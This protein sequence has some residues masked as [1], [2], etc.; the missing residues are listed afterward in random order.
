M[1]AMQLKEGD[2]HV[3]TADAVTTTQLVKYAGASGDFNRIHFD[4]EFARNAGLGDIIAHGMLTMAFAGRCLT[5]M[6]LHPDYVHTFSARFLAP[7]KV[8]SIVKV[9]A[10]VLGFDE[11]LANV[12]LHASVAGKMVMYGNAKLLASHEA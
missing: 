10:K 12:E 8:G 9:E 11:L 4:Q 7:V 1:Q 3:F 6:V 5:E 2:T